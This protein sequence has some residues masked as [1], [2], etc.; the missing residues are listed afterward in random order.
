MSQSRASM[1]EPHNGPSGN[2]A[3]SAAERRAFIQ[4]ARGKQ[5]A[6]SVFRNC[7]VVN[8]FSNEVY[9]ADVAIAYGRVAGIGRPGTY[10][11]VKSIDCG[12]HY[13]VPGLI[14]A[15][16]HVEDALLVPGEFVRALAPHGT[17]TCISDPHEIANVSGVPGL[18]WMLAASEH[19]PLRLMLTLPSCVPA[20][21]YESAGASLTAS[22][23]AP[24]AAH[25]LIASVGEVMNY[26][27][28][29]EGDQTL[30]DVIALSQPA[31]VTPRGLAVD[32]HAPE[33]MG[34]DLC[35]YVA[36]GV[37]SDHE[38]VSAAEALEK[39]RLGMWLWVREGSTRNLDELLPIILEH[40]PERC[41]FVADDR[42]PGDLLREGDL[43]AIIRKAVG[44][45]LDPIQAIRMA[46]L[47]PAQYFG[48]TNRGAIA[49]GYLADLL[50]VPDLR[51]FRPRQVY[52]GGQ[53][54][55]ED[56]QALFTAPALP[57]DWT[58]AVE[59]TVRLRDFSVERLRLPGQSG[60]ARVIGLIHDQIVTEDRR[61]E[62]Q[63]HNGQ[64]ISD[65][66]RDILKI[67]VVERYGGGRV[68]VGLLHGLRLRKG[69]D[70]L[71]RCSRCP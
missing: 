41:G 56:G 64:I 36:A 35:G 14:E 44:K 45:G 51:N 63:S 20:S 65:P 33:L 32:G 49:P 30:L 62:V 10:T 27:G 5:A 31:T 52:V 60:T 24:L 7:R 34:L 42:T 4:I 43:D 13:L 16:T 53:L 50:V 6:E 12:G 55:A 17:T 26:P 1:D 28:V 37:Q 58:E 59:R 18:R 2:D 19:L 54:I 23:L 38:S 8:V 66:E 61:V 70:G 46:S 25:P 71:I 47:H 29:L 48:F 11:G 67:A 68:G 21:P 3:L 40:A 15:H 57:S 22:D 9:E 69:G 39:L